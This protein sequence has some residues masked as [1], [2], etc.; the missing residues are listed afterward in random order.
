MHTL[1]PEY[2]ELNAAGVIDEST[3]ARAIALDG[4]EIFSAF[5]EIRFTL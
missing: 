2:R 3:T 5:E 4:G 1:E